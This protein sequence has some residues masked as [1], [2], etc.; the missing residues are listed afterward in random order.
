MITVSCG[1]CAQLASA[2][3]PSSS[4]NDAVAFQIDAAHTGTQVDSTL[5]IPFSQLWKVTLPGYISYPIITTD[6]A[7]VTATDETGVPSVWSLDIATGQTRWKKTLT[8]VPGG[9]IWSNAT[10][11]LGRVFA[12]GYSGI[13]TAFDTTTGAQLWSTQL[14]D[15]F[16]FSSPP[17]AAGGTVY[18]VASG[19]SVGVV[20]AIDENTGS[21]LAKR[22]VNGSGDHSSPALSSSSVFVSS[23]CNQD[24]ALDP[25]SLVVQWQFLGP[26][27]GGGGRTAVFSGN[28]VLTRDWAGTGNLILDATTGA[29]LGTFGSSLLSQPASMPAS[30]GNSIWYLNA[31][32]LVADDISNPAAPHQLWSFAGDGHLVTA[33]LMISA[34]SNRAVIEGSSTGMLYALNAQTGAVEWSANVGSSISAP[35]ENN[36]ASPLTGLSAGHGVLLVPAGNTLTAFVGAPAAPAVPASAVSRSNLCMLMLIILIAGVLATRLTSH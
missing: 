3:A 18:A 8:P 31:G 21:V 36:V 17:T 7:F 27:S 34:G 10:I 15:V 29:E 28:R 16:S 25:S 9:R 2:T 30:Q 20:Y 26:C 6:S 14:P 19:G 4:S 32:S 33:P 13:M 22:F 24:S 11:D 12:V 23:A 1:L 5:T 35:D